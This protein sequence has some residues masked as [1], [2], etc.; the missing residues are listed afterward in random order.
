MSTITKLTTQSTMY[1]LRPHFPINQWRMAR[2]WRHL[3][4]LQTRET[5]RGFGAV[6]T[7]ENR[8][9]TKLILL[10]DQQGSMEPFSPFIDSFIKSISRAKLFDQTFLYYFHDCPEGFLYE[11]SSLTTTLSLERVL[12]EQV[13]D[14]S[15]I[16]VSDAGAAYGYYERRRLENT[17]TFLQILET[18]T[19]LYAWLNPMPFSCWKSTTAEDIARVVSMFPMDEEGLNN[20]LEYL[21][22]VSITSGER[23]DAR[24]TR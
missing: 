3:R 10:L 20:A 16:I 24:E 5:S 14:S 15:V 23:P 13:K 21:I 4:D 7:S 18:F 19:D 6:D 8:N 11:Q 17:K 9:Q 2:I 1:T 22:R 12:S